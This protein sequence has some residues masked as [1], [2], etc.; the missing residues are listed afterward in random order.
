MNAKLAAAS[1]FFIVLSICLIAYWPGLNGPFLFDDFASWAV[2]F[3]VEKVLF[4][5]FSIC[6]RPRVDLKRIVMFLFYF[7]GCMLL[8]HLLFFINIVQLIFSFIIE[9]I[10]PRFRIPEF[11]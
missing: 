7:L 11:H 5:Q 3:L 4:R 2:D 6:Y 10:R 8:V 9:E 1:F